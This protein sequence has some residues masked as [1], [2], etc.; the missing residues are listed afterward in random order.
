[1]SFSKLSLG[2]LTMFGLSIGAMVLFQNCSPV[3]MAAADPAVAA[4]AAASAAVETGV[5]QPA[6]DNSN[7]GKVLTPAPAPVASL[8]SDEDEAS[9]DEG[10]DAGLG[11]VCIG[12]GIKVTK[13]AIVKCADGE[14]NCVVICNA[15][16]TATV[17]FK[18]ARKLIPAGATVGAC[19]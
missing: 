9:E 17:T 5:A 12:N 8:E 6:S 1:M 2:S 7:G 4:K 3:Q 15:K 10:K 13:D 11:E 14:P 19:K 16:E 18:E